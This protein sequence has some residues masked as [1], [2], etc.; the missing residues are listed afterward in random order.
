MEVN[1]KYSKCL[2]EAAFY[3]YTLLTVTLV[4]CVVLQVWRAD[5]NIP[6]DYGMELNNDVLGA[7]T[8]IKSYMRNGFSWEQS[9]FSAPFFTDRKGEFGVDRVV[10]LLE[11]LCSRIFSSYGGSLNAL[12]LMSFLTTG[13]TAAYS[14]RCLR[15]SRK[16]SLAGAIIYTFL[17]YHMMRGEM[18]LYLSFYYSAPLAVLI[19]L[20]ITD[21]SLLAGH[22]S[23]NRIGRVKRGYMLCGLFAWI[24][25]LQQPYY[26]FF[27]AIG[28]GFALLY[29]LCR[30]HFGKAV[31]SMAYLLVIAITT[32]V[33]NAQAILHTSD[34]AMKYM[35]EQ[36]TVK[37]IEAYGLKII[38][39]LLPIQNHRLTILAKLRQQY[40]NLVN[41]GNSEEAWVSLGLILSLCFCAALAAVLING[42]VDLRIRVCGSFILAFVLVATVGGGSSAIGMIFSLLRCY[43]R[44]VVYIAM[45][46]VIVFGVLAEKLE[47]YLRTRKVPRAIR[48][49]LLLLPAVFA[50]WD[51]TSLENI[52]NYAETR[53]EYLRA[54]KFVRSIEAEMPEGACIFQLPLLPTGTTSIRE[55]KDNE[56][57]KPYLHA[58]STRWL[59]MYSV[60]SRTDQWVNLLHGLPLR[61]VADILVCCDFQG[62]YMDSRGFTSEQW[63]AALAVMDS[64]GDDQV[65]HSEDGL[66]VFY[67][68]RDHAADLK[69]RIGAEKMEEYGDFWLNCPDLTC[70]S[71]S[72]LPYTM[73]V[74]PLD[75]GML[76][77]SG[78][79]QYGPYITIS[80]GDYIVYVTGN[81]LTD[82]TYDV[83]YASGTI[84]LPLHFLSTESDLVRYSFHVEEEITGAEI[85]CTN[86][87]E[88]NAL[89]RGIYLFRK[90]QSRERA[91]IEQFLH[92]GGPAQ[93]FDSP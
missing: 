20:W 31:E 36:R 47:D 75:D 21:E 91:A 70:F 74:S 60:G 35:L 42:R 79:I 67:G 82:L 25:G 30:K 39:L 76:L 3:L 92:P 68:L 29:S 40:D 52:Y 80:P 12:Y 48:C 87:T 33:G 71:A 18:H 28:I 59:H 7:S 44:M 63:E 46:C 55:L 13:L 19:M 16:I 34:P 8:W 51:Q 89:L 2:A 24:I 86:A 26:A 11:I 14:L 5:W 53:E 88:E 69:E 50:V 1:K 72:S 32:L 58:E 62:V 45:F 78:C 81:Q 66:K 93:E 54:E 56:L 15:F 83:S 85:R 27:A 38:H 6:F 64:V 41:A 49:G 61:T 23:Q 43:N 10:L 22:L 73:A 57:S 4:W 17:Q 9:D 90:D 37:A 84:Q 77:P 65:I